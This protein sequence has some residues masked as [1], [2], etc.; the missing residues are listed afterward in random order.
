[1]SRDRDD[2][3]SL[4]GPCFGPV[5][6]IGPTNSVMGFLGPWGIIIFPIASIGAK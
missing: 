2:R 5:E 6:P 3:P 1:M 4:Y